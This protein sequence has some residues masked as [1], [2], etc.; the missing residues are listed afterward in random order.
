M[1]EP[2]EVEVEVEYEEF[3]SVTGSALEVGAEGQ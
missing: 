2:S 3:D 1:S